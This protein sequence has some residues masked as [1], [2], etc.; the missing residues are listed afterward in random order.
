MRDGETKFIGARR[1]VNQ[2]RQILHR[3][4]DLHALVQV[5]AA[6]KHLR[7]AH[8]ELDGES[9]TYRPPDRLKH[10]SCQPHPVLQTPAVLVRPM[11]E[12]RGQELVDQPAVAAVN[13]DHLISAQLCQFRILI[14]RLY[15]ILNLFFTKRRHRKSVRTGARARP[16]L[17]HGFLF[18]FVQQIGARILAR[19]RQLHAR[20]RAVPL[21]G[22]RR[23]GEAGHRSHRLRI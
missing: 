16:V 18:I 11:I 19:M 23:I 9:G 8:P 21:D 7:T 14:V 1:N 10:L 5:I 3:L 6:F 17:S 20:H 2:I 12:I 13:H 15:D 4:R 22:I